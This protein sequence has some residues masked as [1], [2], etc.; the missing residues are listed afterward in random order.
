LVFTGFLQLADALRRL[1]C[2]KE[3]LKALLPVADKFPDE[4]RIAYQLACYCC[5]VGDRKRAWQ[6]LTRAIGVAGM[7]DIR[8][9]ALDE[10]DLEALWVDI[11]EI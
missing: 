11:A 3:A 9:K 4:W 6:W 5:R 10:P 7:V 2:T 8:L 1:D